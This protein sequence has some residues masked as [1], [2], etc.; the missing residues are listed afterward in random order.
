MRAHAAA[1][2]TKWENFKNMLSSFLKWRSK[3]KKCIY[4]KMGKRE[5]GE[6]GSEIPSLM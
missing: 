5:R 3:K 4:K 1:T 6:R 2:N